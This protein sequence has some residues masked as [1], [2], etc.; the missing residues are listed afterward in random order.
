MNG[1]FASAITHLGD[2]S[3]DVRLGGI[4]ALERIA[5]T[6]QTD[7]QAIEEVLC[8]RERARRYRAEWVR[9]TL[10]PR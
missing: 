9:R 1:S 4:Y 3:L 2:P 5:R 8:L 10:L 6:S 7:R